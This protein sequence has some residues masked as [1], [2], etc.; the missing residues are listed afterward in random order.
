MAKRGIKIFVRAYNPKGGI[1]NSSYFLM[2]DVHS[3]DIIAGVSSYR[4]S[5]SNNSK[6]KALNLKLIINV[7]LISI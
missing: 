7:G 5:A 4:P 1:I 2:M 6:I 3:I